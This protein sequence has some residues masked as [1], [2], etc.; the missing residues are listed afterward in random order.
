MKIIENFKNMK[1]E[2][3]LFIPISFQPQCFVLSSL[4]SLFLLYLDSH[5]LYLDLLV[6]LDLLKSWPVFPVLACE[7]TFSTAGNLFAGRISQ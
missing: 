6:F 2:I 5:F 1:K 3:F 7:N 4:N